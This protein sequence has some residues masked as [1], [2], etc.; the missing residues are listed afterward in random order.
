MRSAVSKGDYAVSDY[1]SLNN[2][3][4]LR[5][6]LQ[7]YA[8][9]VITT[10]WDIQESYGPGDAEWELSNKNKFRMRQPEM[11]TIVQRTIPLV[12]ASPSDSTLAA[13][14]LTQF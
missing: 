7:E 10:V 12:M 2:D 14:E 1:G 4:D 8:Y 13:F 5:V 3:E 6:I 9:W 11:F